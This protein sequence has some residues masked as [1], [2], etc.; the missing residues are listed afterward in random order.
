M[1]V[2]A[3]DS[4]RSWSETAEFVR[5]YL[6]AF[7][8]DAD[9][10]LMIATAGEPAAET[11]GRRVLRLLEKLKIPQERCADVS[12]SDEADLTAWRADIAAARIID[13]RNVEDRSPSA[14]RRLIEV[15]RA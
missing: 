15:V 5:R 2:A 6:Q 1:F 14:L 4:E 8:A 7:D 12:I 10:S 9:V 3:V 13:V 11:I